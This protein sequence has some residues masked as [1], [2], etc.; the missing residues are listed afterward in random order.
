[1]TSFAGIQLGKGKSNLRECKIPYELKV[2]F[3]VCKLCKLK[4]QY[5]SAKYH[6][7]ANKIRSFIREEEILSANP[8]AHYSKADPKYM[9]ERK[10]N[11]KISKQEQQR[12]IR[13]NERHVK[14]KNIVEGEMKN[15]F[16]K[17]NDPNN[18]MNIFKN[19][20]IPFNEESEDKKVKK[21]IEERKMEMELKDILYYRPNPAYF[22]WFEV[23]VPITSVPEKLEDCLTLEEHKAHRTM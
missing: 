14:R 18:I 4:T 8:T 3:F 17:P 10:I 22:E 11:P 12:L 19:I 2:M 5:W 23:G 21:Q 9:P 7:I 13:M 16:N 20:K 6:D 15:L 1:V